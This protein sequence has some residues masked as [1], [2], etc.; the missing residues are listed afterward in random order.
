MVLY[1]V[2]SLQRIGLDIKM[3][4]GKKTP[5]AGYFHLTAVKNSLSKIKNKPY[6]TVTT[7]LANLEGI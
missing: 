1:S 2:D 6:S 7:A 4:L 5:K 3:I